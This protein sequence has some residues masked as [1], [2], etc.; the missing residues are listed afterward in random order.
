MIL[1]GEI[2]N[3]TSGFL[4]KLGYETI[5][6]DFKTP[7]KSSRYNYLQPVIDAVNEENY[8]KAEE[9]AWD[10]TTSLVGND[11]SKMER[12]W[13]DGEMSIIARNNYGCCL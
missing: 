1:S 12:I 13:K 9:Y 8:R 3:Y 6:I 10:I 7:Q 5:V 2:Y 4:E 11:D